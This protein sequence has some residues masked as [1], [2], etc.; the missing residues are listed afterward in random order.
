[1]VNYL[2]YITPLVS[3]QRQVDAIYFDFSSAF[4]LVSHALLLS[5]LSS[6][7]LSSAYVSWFC[8]YLTDRFS[9][10]KISGNF[11]APFRILA[12]VPKGSVLG[13]MLFN[14]FIDDICKVITHSKFLLFADDIKIFRAIISLDDSTQLQLNIDSIQRWC[15]ANFI[16]LNTGKTRAI[17]FSRKIN[18]LFF[19]INLGIFILHVLIV[20]RI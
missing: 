13:P 16:N 9:C 3:S 12:G 4:D 5:K 20:L 18:T 14:V 15:T 1:L 2:D 17:T 11:S 7:G 19:N 10:V 8:S 6:F